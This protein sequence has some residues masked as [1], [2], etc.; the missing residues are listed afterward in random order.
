MRGGV[1][2]GGVQER[3]RRDGPRGDISNYT[4]SSLLCDSYF[5]HITEG[6]LYNPSLFTGDQPPCWTMVEEYLEL[7]KV[8]PTHL[9]YIRGHLFKLWH[10]V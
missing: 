10:H 7:V 8:Y 9:S 4:Q 3:K 2:E 6:N 1:E 5:F